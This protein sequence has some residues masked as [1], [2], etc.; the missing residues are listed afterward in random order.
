MIGLS[1]LAGIIF[2][3]HAEPLQQQTMVTIA[4]SLVEMASQDGVINDKERNLL[5]TKFPLKEQVDP[6]L[7]FTLNRSNLPQSMSLLDITTQQKE[8][9]LHFMGL[10][11]L[12]DGQISNKEKD[13]FTKHKTAFSDPKIQNTD[14]KEYFMQSQKILNRIQHEPMLDTMRELARAQKKYHKIHK[15][16][17]STKTCPQ[18]TASSTIAWKECKAQFANFPWVT[19]DTVHGSYKME[20]TKNAFV[21]TG[22]ID[23][24]G[25]GTSATYVSTHTAPSPKRIGNQDAD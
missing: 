23:I 10:V 13:Y 11:A 3:A 16:Y 9:F 4:A 17:L 12:V 15:R 25:D 24:D 5:A 19:P 21:I 14:T 8:G 7:V 1:W 2:S 20:G 6:V 18:Q 22:T